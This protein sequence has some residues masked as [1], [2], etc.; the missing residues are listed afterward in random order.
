[1]CD[2]HGPKV[3][4]VGPGGDWTC[5]MSW[6]DPQVA[7]PDGWGKF[8]LNV[9]ANGCYTATG[10]TKLTGFLTI[11]DARG[12][13][14]TNPLF[15]FDSCFDP[16][17]SNA[18]TG[19]VFPSVLTVSST[20]LGTGPDGPTV[21]VSCSLGE[22]G[23]AGTVAARAADGTT[24]TGTY[25][26]EPGRKAPVDLTGVLPGPVELSFTPRT[27]TAPEPVRLPAP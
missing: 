26:L 5:L 6:T 17:G 21:D 13:D 4:D 7:L 18:P 12:R 11:S 1:M 10:P 2:K 25:D 16:H 23:C 14:V 15:E 20:A 3:A 9:H 22:Q 19:V 8:E 24:G 27:G